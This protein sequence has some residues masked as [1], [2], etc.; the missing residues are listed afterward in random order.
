MMRHPWVCL[1]GALAVLCLAAAPAANLRV[2]LHVDRA[3]LSDSGAGTG[4]EQMERDG[5]ANVTFVALP[6][7]AGTDPVDTSALITALT[8]EPHVTH[9]SAL[10]NG[11]DLTV[12]A[13]GD[14]LPVDN[15]AS[16]VLVRTIRSLAADSLPARQ[17][18]FTGGPAAALVDYRAATDAA[19]GQVAI[20]VLAGAFLLMLVM[21]RSLLL[22]L[23]AVA[24]GP[25]PGMV[26]TLR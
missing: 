2:G 10:D 6:H 9:S 15:P 26:D 16:A 17:P 4:L 18:V 14:D 5:F 21:F 3:A 11:R 7:P 25:S 24:M 19:V 13:V 8:A 20:I 23:K 1:F 12:V 22:P